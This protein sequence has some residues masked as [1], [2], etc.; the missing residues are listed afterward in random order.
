MVSRIVQK[1]SEA[2]RYSIEYQFVYIKWFDEIELQ[3]LVVRDPQDSV[4]ITEPEVELDFDIMSIIGGKSIKLDQIRLHHP[5]VSLIRDVDSAYFNIDYFLVGIKDFLNPKRKKPKPVFIGSVKINQG[6]FTLNDRKRDTILTRFDQFH[7]RIDDLEAFLSGF[8]TASD[9]VE[10]QINQLSGRNRLHKLDI[11]ELQSYFRMSNHALEFDNLYGE[12]GNSIL[13]DSLVFRYNQ[14]SDLGYFLDSVTIQAHLN[15]SVLDTRNLATFAPQLRNLSDRYSISGDF[16]GQVGRFGLRNAEISFGS[17]SLVKGEVSLNGLPDIEETFIGLNFQDSRIDGKDLIPYI[18][19]PNFKLLRKF[20]LVDFDGQF[21]GF[22]ADFVAFGTF[23]TA[24]GKVTSDINLKLHEDPAKAF[25][26]GKVTLYDFDAGA[27]INE[28]QLFQ[29][30]DMTGDIKG[31]GLTLSTADFHLNAEFGKLGFKHYDYQNIMTNARLTE[32][33]FEGSLEIQDPNLKFTSDV[34]IDLR[35]RTDHIKVSADLEIAFLKNLKLSDKD[36]SISSVVELD[37]RGL[38]V[39]SIVGTIGL[40]NIFATFYGRNLYIDQIQVTS[41]LEESFRFLSWDSDRVNFELAGNFDYTSTYQDLR[42]T[43][44]E[45]QLILL[46][47]RDS[48]LEF[49]AR[50]DRKLPKDYQLHYLFN[51]RDINPFLALVAPGWSISPGTTLEGDLIGGKSSLFS[52]RS[53]VDTLGYNDYRFYSNE[54]GISTSK[55]RDTTDVL[56]FIYLFSENPDFPPVSE[57][58]NFSFEGVWADDHID[59]RSGLY[60]SNDNQAKIGGNLKFE[61]NHT[62]IRFKPSDIVFLGNR[63]EFIDAN[64]IAF[65]NQEIDFHQFGI[66]NLNQKVVLNGVVSLD[67]SESLRLEV[68]DFRLENLTPI[69]QQSL[70][71]TANGYALMRNLLK[72]AFI[73]SEMEIDRLQIGDFEVGELTNQALWDPTF[74]KFKMHFGVTR[75]QTKI[76]SIDGFFDPLVSEEQLDLAARFE[77]AHLSIFEP[78]IGDTFSEIAGQ[79]SGAFEITGNL[80]RPVL[81]GRGYIEEGS[82][83]INYLNTAYTF[84]GLIL[85]DEN[86]IGVRELRVLDDQANEATLDGGIFHDGFRNFAVDLSGEVR[87]FK[88]LNTSFKDNDL[89]YGNMMVTGSIDFLGTIDNLTISAEAITEKGTQLFIPMGSS[90]SIEQK[91]FIQ[92]VSFRDSTFRDVEDEVKSVNLKG[93]TL[94][95]D[96]EVTADAYTEIIFDIKTG[97]IIRGRGSGS[98]QLDTKGDEFNMFGDFVLDQGSYNFTL[99]SLIN[100]E[101]EIQPGSRISWYGDPYEGILDIKAHY[102]Q[103]AS[104][105]PI[106]ADTS[107]SSAP[108]VRRAY[109]TTVILDLKGL[110][111]AP[112]IGFDIIVEDFPQNIVANGQGIS[113]QTEYD[114]F[115]NK[116]DTDEQ[117]LKRQVFSLIILKRFSI[118]NSFELGGGGTL[119]SSVSEFISNQLFYWMS[120]VDENLEISVDLGQLD[121]EVFNSLQ[122]RLSYTFLEGRL[123]VTGDGGQNVG[124]LAGALSVE[125]LITEDGQLKIKLSLGSNY[126]STTSSLDNTYNYNTYRGSLVW[127]KSFPDFSKQLRRARERAEKR[128]K[129]GLE[130]TSSGLKEEEEIRT[131]QQ[132]EI[133]EDHE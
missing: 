27:L 60:R 101:F 90:A 104:M 35:Q 117:E 126:T 20:G 79:A 14:R 129:E 51:L 72:N 52:L 91:D 86:E 4:M 88:V 92:F 85:L 100:K 33:F 120:Q 1:L 13:R 110:L 106:L 2:T 118:P 89:F 8:H 53:L 11:N 56:A 19:S 112:E 70:S 26:D 9:T 34:S 45:Y 93:L 82:G 57:F 108:D 32:E 131:R 95:L 127:S 111:L 65:D 122:L 29:K 16:A 42:N 17:R 132:E 87:N 116:I 31:T 109:P 77:K 18:N 49:Y 128:T 114:A 69:V 81:K 68:E 94:K 24:L 71:G 48:L 103:F 22:P 21:L 67:S 5:K 102:R 37:V 130:P 64:R 12:L 84:N 119:G 74:D 66:H 123:R 7:F 76:I 43:V 54:I 121:D 28:P 133:G 55:T 62:D 115:K 107:I 59:W 113:L 36:L 58:K 47:Q 3:G 105:A 50:P 61:S 63:W 96:L 83:K 80:N 6:S 10:F 99:Y 38:H 98:F 44:E 75:D 73:E 124:G 30:I 23:S 97:D 15:N 125:S 25:Y 46:N 40:R 78:F 39:D 41:Q